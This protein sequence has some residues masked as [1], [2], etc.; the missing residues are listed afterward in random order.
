MRVLYMSG[1]T[2]QSAGDRVGF[3]RGAAFVE[4]P[5]TAA[6]FVRQVRDALDR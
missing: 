3:D 5:F 2:Q 6:D 1:Y 4:K